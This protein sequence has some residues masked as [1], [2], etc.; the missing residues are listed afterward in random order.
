MAASEEEWPAIVRLTRADADQVWLLSIE[1]GWNQIVA[2]WRLMIDLGRAFGIRDGSGWI[3]T[4]LAL[5]VA[6]ALWWISMVLVRQGRR[7]QGLGTRLLS[8]CMAEAD[9]AGAAMG[10]DATEF[11][12]PVYLPLGFRDAWRLTRWNAS[13]GRRSDTH[14]PQGIRLRPAHT[15]DLGRIAELDGARSGF[16]RPTILANLFT[17]APHLARIAERED[18]GL[19]GYVLGRDG[20]RAAQIG[21]VIAEDQAIARALMA[22]ALGNACGSAIIDVPDRNTSIAT[23]LASLGAKAP[24]GYTRMVRGATTLAGTGDG[25]FAIAG[26]ELA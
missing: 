11:G 12:R 19:V 17:R 25:V 14:C 8:R 15:A 21:P 24:R 18:G 1:A 6:P 16:T 22:E 7:G 5:P 23:W 10:L 13:G 3:A 2:D 9:G 26:P 4:A 20:Y